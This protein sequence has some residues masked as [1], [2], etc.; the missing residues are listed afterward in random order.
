MGNKY[1]IGT[2][3]G[4]VDATTNGGGTGVDASAGSNVPWATLEYA[5]DTMAD[6]DVLYI[7]PGI[8][9]DVV[10]VGVTPTGETIVRG[11]PLNTVGFKNAAGILLTAGPVLITDML[12]D[13]VSAPTNNATI[14]LSGK[15]YLTLENLWVENWANSQAVLIAAGCQHITIRK[16]FLYA[17]TEA[18]IFITSTADVPSAFLL[19]QS[20]VMN[21]GSNPCVKV[22]GTKTNT[23]EYDIGITIRNCLMLGSSFNV[24]F[25]VTATATYFAAGHIVQNC[26]FP[27][28]YGI[29]VSTGYTSALTTKMQVK[30]C[31]LGGAQGLQQAYSSSSDSDHMIEDYN[32][33]DCTTPLTKITKGANTV[34][35]A[36]SAFAR[37]VRMDYGQSEL[38]GFQ[39]KSLC[40]PWPTSRSIGYGN[41]ST[42][43]A[44]AVDLFNRVR[45]SGSGVAAAS[46]L[47]GV[48]AIE[49]HNFGV[50]DTA[51]KDA[52]DA[53][54]K[55]VGPG[56]H[57]FII[58][59]SAAATTISIKVRYDSSTYG[60]TN[61]PT[62]TLLDLEGFCAIGGNTEVETATTDA[63]DAWETLTFTAFTPTRKG[64]VRLRLTNR[65]S[66]A[67]DIC[68]FDTLNVV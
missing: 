8:W 23:A 56:D 24:L 12:T 57:E 44:L 65:G 31:Y 38:W 30:N 1:L 27:F 19:E 59:V 4:G 14:D 28:G 60:G 11:D 29:K 15:D 45:P 63:S 9:R 50:T 51:T 13:D 49:L 48:G 32:L 7:A 36:G 67:D 26:T 52:G 55:L 53:S 64:V 37:A 41:D 2:D 5:L 22:Y 42:P 62:A 35:Y 33:I 66:G 20:I 46:V 43:T 40:H 16:C 39:K 61:Y 47:A 68:W 18:T 17:N 21:G 6:G 34:I 25:D 58:P 54:V 10:T 3:N